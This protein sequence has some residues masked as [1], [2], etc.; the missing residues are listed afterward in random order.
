MVSD[1]DLLGKARLCI[2]AGGSG[3]YSA[4]YLAT[5]LDKAIEITAQLKQIIKEGKT[6]K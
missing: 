3:S 5:S 4:A 2:E 6:K 1:E